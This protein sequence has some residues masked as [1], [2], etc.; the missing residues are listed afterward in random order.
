MNLP[1]FGLLFLTM[2][3]SIFSHAQNSIP[4]YEKDIPNSKPGNDEEKSETTGGIT[5][6]SKISRP[7]LTVFLPEPAKANGTSVVICPG[8]GYRINAI[9]HEGFEVAKKFTEMGVAAFVLKYRIPD[10]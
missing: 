6:V 3:G 10:D 5:R 2:L 8:G 4:L 9:D 1:S 7:T